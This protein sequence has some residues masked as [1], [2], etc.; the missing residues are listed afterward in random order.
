MC[1]RQCLSKD[2]AALNA[3]RR[4]GLTGLKATELPVKVEKGEYTLIVI[5][6]FV[7]LPDVIEK[8]ARKHRV[9]PEEV[10]EIFYNRPQCHKR[11]RGTRIGED[12]YAVSGQSDAGRYLIVF[13]IYQPDR[14]LALIL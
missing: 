12:V 4:T 9:I 6:D 11:K 14:H 13:F 2:A 7:W 3:T 5:D 8:L 1:R 10:E